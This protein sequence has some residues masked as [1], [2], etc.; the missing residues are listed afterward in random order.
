MRRE[1]SLSALL[2][3]VVCVAFSAVLLVM[4]LFAT[5]AA[6]AQNTQTAAA[7]AA[8][9]LTAAEDVP[10]QVEKPRYWTNKL[11]TNISF[12]QTF[13]SQWAAG[14]YN[15]VSLSGTID[16]SASTAPTNP[17]SRRTRT[18]STSSPNGATRPR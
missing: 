8:A 1:I 14:G 9:A 3:R 7:E 2:F 12:G 13:L 6:Q 11:V 10:E 15:N 18:A 5:L 4:A 16:G 17:S